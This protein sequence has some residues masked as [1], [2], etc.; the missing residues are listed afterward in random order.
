VKDLTSGLG[1]G[2]W[3]PSH[4]RSTS[5]GARP[6][7]MQDDRNGGATWKQN[8]GN[9]FNPLAR[10]TAKRVRAASA[11]LSR[12]RWRGAGGGKRSA[13]RIPATRSVSERVRW[14]P[15]IRTPS[16]PGWTRPVDDHGF[17]T[18]HATQNACGTF[19]CW[20]SGFWRV[21]RVGPRQA[22]PRL[23]GWLRHHRHRGER[24]PCP[25]RGQRMRGS[26]RRP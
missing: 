24:C 17:G 8:D 19:P 16:W 10:Y 14:R 1:S 20:P 9:A 23:S 25:R 5:W 4:R 22:P 6:Y 15:G 7:R 18:P 13:F 2:K 26:P 12:C 3:G 11:S 21:P